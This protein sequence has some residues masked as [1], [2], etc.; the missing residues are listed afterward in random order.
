MKRKILIKGLAVAAAVL[1]LIPF[2]SFAASIAWLAN[3]DDT[4]YFSFTY[5]PDDINNESF[6][7]FDWNNPSNVLQVIPE[8]GGAGIVTFSNSTG[9]WIATN[10]NGTLTFHS[11]AIFGFYFQIAD[12]DPIEYNYEQI[13]NLDWYEFTGVDADTDMIVMAHDINP[14]PI[15]TTA[16]IFGTGLI[17]LVGIRR[18]FRS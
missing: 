2:N 3:S 12:G 1:F 7:M 15:P 8:N 9:S 17:G 5:D 11:D 18:K 6:W 10:G 4:A 16:L 13:G 14:I